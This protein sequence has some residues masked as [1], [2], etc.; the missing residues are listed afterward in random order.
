MLA[1]RNYK[2]ASMKSLKTFE[3]RHLSRSLFSLFLSFSTLIRKLK[4]KITR[5][6]YLEDYSKE[7]YTVEKVFLNTWVIFFF[8]KSYHFV[9]LT[10]VRTGKVG[11]IFLDKTPSKV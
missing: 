10:V 8:L 5:V 2:S 9:Y 11:R 7:K 3:R 1:C 6:A 4:M